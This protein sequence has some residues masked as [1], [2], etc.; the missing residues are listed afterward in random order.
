MKHIDII[1]F[2]FQQGSSKNVPNSQGLVNKG[3]KDDAYIVILVLELSLLSHCTIFP[4]IMHAIN[5]SK[6][7]RKTFCFIDFHLFLQ[8]KP[9]WVF[10]IC[11]FKTSSHCNHKL[12]HTFHGDAFSRPQYW[13][14]T[15]TN[16]F[17]KQEFTK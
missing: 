17:N 5:G 1:K 12:L 10:Q 13:S 8:L 4:L 11:G 16:T 2:I 14:I 6:H 7:T 15:Y 9:C 3:L